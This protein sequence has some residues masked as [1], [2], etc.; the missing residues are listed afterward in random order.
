MSSLRLILLSIGH[1]WKMNVAV[2]CG[3]AGQAWRDPGGKRHGSQAGIRGYDAAAHS[4]SDCCS[5]AR[6]FWAAA[7]SA[8]AAERIR[9]ARCIARAAQRARPGQ[10][11]LP[12]LAEISHR[13]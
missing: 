10:R 13:M 9:L 11:D 12:P 7:E 5:R 1:F 2:A 8:R 6:P 3:V 4:P